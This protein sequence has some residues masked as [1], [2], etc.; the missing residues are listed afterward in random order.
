MG[1]ILHKK[2]LLS[3]I[4][5]NARYTGKLYKSV[6]SWATRTDLWQTWEQIYGNLEDDER[7]TNARNF[8][9]ANES[10]MLEGTDVL[11]PAREDYYSLMVT[12][13]EIGPRAFSKENQN[14]PISDETAIFTEMH[15][16]TETEKGLKVDKSGVVIPWTHLRPFGAI[17]PATGQTK[18]KT[19]KLGDYA[20][21]IVG[22]VD[23]RGRLFV[24]ND[25][26]RRAPPSEQIE[27]ILDFDELERFEKFGVE[28]NLYRNILL[29]N[30]EAAR[31]A[32]EKKRK[33]AGMKNYGMQVQFQEIVQVENK[34]KRIFSLEPKVKTGWILFNRTVSAEFKSQMESFPMGEHD[35]C[36]DALEMLWSL[37]NNR[38]ESSGTSADPRKGTY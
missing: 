6:I 24:K 7:H 10:E 27:C 22:Y 15:W 29:E 17:D 20:C 1:T 26:T 25:W 9:E 28:T 18:A 35:D 19:G 36:P 37:V 2:S 14:D 31:T 32:R 33:D 3:N 4:L 12:R 16:F 5:K 34:Q 21:V 8:F 38:Y 30:L 13:F 11:W 23:P